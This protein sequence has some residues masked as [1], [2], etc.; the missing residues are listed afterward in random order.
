M[1]TGL[2]DDLFKKFGGT[3]EPPM[4]RSKT[5]VPIIS[6]TD[7][8]ILALE[9]K[10]LTVVLET[11][12]VRQRI[13]KSNLHV[14]S[15]AFVNGPRADGV[16]QNTTALFV[17]GPTLGVDT[18]YPLAPGSAAAP[19]GGNVSFGPCNLGNIY[20]IGATVGDVLRV[21]YFA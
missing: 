17:G 14:Q 20:V 2:R 15:V 4:I 18:G 3:K 7:P 13:T 5:V 9:L 10:T 12:N 21:T 8:A 19:I 1:L 16:T 6:V 11:A